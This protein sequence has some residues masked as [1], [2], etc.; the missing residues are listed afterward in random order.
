MHLGVTYIPVYV[1]LISAVATLLSG[2]LIGR[3]WTYRISLRKLEDDREDREAG[4]RRL[5]REEARKDFELLLRVVT[6]QRDDAF[7]KIDQQ[8]VRFEHV[9][10]ELQ[11]LRLSRDLDPFPHWIVD[12]EG[13]YLYVN[14][15]FESAF[16]R[17]R[18]ITPK[19][20]IG[21]KHEKIFPADFASKLRLLDAQA[22]VRADHQARAVLSINSRKV[23]VHKFPICVHGLPVAFAGYI[24][25]ME[26][27]AA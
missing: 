24:T 5:E 20:M 27:L 8:N 12:L 9:E 21:E 3:Y 15:E 17:H 1:A 2:A 13:R 19:Q 6:E 22:K 14:A 10:L 25:E 18:Q 4:R 16:L 11:G 23:T 7:A 26:E